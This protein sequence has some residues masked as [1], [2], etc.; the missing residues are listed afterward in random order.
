MKAT[1]SSALAL[2]V[3]GVIAC[4]AAQ[5]CEPPALADTVSAVAKPQPAA[6]FAAVTGDMSMPQIF[7]SLG[8]AARDIGSGVYIFEWDVADGR[9]FRVSATSLCAKPLKIG[10]HP[11]TKPAIKQ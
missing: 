2:T 9:V 10:L 1:A 5:A 8:P 6:A 7:K 4:S 11:A 3:P